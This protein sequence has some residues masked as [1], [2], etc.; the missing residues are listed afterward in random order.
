MEKGRWRKK[1]F[2]QKSQIN[3]TFFIGHPTVSAARQTKAFSAE[4]TERSWMREDL[5]FPFRFPKCRNDRISPLHGIPPWDALLSLSL[6][7]SLTH[8]LPLPLLQL[9]QLYKEQQESRKEL[10]SSSSLPP[11]S[12]KGLSA[13]AEGRRRREGISFSQSSGVGL[14]LSLPPRL[15]S[16]LHRA[17][18]SFPPFH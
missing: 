4:E 6:C 9:N 8:S 2:H 14:P 11:L 5:S 3:Q 7:L 10:S 1:K 18:F 15:S 13:F 17:K 16:P 12:R